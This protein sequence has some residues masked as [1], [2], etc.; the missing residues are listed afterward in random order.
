MRVVAAGLCLAALSL[1]APALAQTGDEPRE[2]RETMDQIF[3][4]LRVVLPL[5]LR[6]E[7]FADPALRDRILAS[8]DALARNGERLEAHGRSRDASFA[9]LS[10]S[11]ARDARGVRERF[12]AGHPEQ[13]RFLLHELTQTCVACHSRLPSPR[14]SS[15]AARFV[16]QEEIAQLPL[17]ERAR[18]EFATRQFDRALQS[19]ERLFADPAVSPDYLDLAGHVDDY[20]ELRLR[21]VG[22][23]APAIAVLE[24]LAARPDA[25][26]ALRED[27]AGWIRSLR[28]LERRRPSGTPLEQARELVRRGDAAARFE[29]D[30]RGLVSYI[31]ASGVLYRDLDRHR[32]HGTELAETYYLLGVI[33]SRIGR[34][35]PISQTESLLEAA[36][37]LSPGA[38][39]AEEAYD[40]LE[41]FLVSGY[42]GSEGLDLPAEERQRLQELRELIDRSRPAP[43]KG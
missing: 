37:R 36:I 10:S 8:L 13:A 43:K 4:A 31:A 9:F 20:L 28:E 7:R 23:P 15:L 40:L 3:E 42:T 33:E 17:D 24:K 27:A 16:S 29:S 11:L 22:D 39:F 25:S 30:R 6:D 18:L 34:A 35:F 19:Y 26:P 2:P 41:E 32:E 12:A 14:A 38:P 21:V 5:S 1:S